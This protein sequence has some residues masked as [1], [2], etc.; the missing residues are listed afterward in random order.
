MKHWD[1]I[2]A[3][4]DCWMMYTDVPKRLTFLE[5][6]SYMCLAH[7]TCVLTIFGCGIRCT[8]PPDKCYS[9]M[10][11]TPPPPL[12]QSVA[13]AIFSK[14]LG[15]VFEGTQA[16]G[17]SLSYLWCMKTLAFC[18]F[19]LFQIYYRLLGTFSGQWTRH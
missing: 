11:I 19:L 8:S 7:L 16:I 15:G 1:L 3:G 4:T 18:I 13:K 17:N 2:R 5:Y 6:A 12:L 14:H 10:F 9:L